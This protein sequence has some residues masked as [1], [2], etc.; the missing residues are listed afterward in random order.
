MKKLMYRVHYT[1]WSDEA[2]STKVYNVFFEEKG[3]AE[4]FVRQM[5]KEYS[6]NASLNNW[7]WEVTV[8][9]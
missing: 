1:K 7:T 8:E 5:K 4:F 3:E 9:D 2:E 6:N